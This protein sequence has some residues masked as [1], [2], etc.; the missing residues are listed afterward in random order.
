MLVDNNQV[1]VYLSSTFW[2]LT[3]SEANATE[4]IIRDAFPATFVIRLSLDENYHVMTSQL[5]RGMGVP[6]TMFHSYQALV[7]SVEEFVNTASF[8]TLFLL[9][10]VDLHNMNDECRSFINSIARGISHQEEGIP[11]ASLLLVVDDPGAHG[12]T[13]LSTLY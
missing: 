1:N 7:E 13:A 2:V 12:D 10:V 9:D 8:R 5:G 4:D 11:Q 3:R 6:V